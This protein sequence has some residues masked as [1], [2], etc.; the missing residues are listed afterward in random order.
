[1]KFSF[2]KLEGF[3]K[4]E[5]KSEIVEEGTTRETDPSGSIRYSKTVMIEDLNYAIDLHQDKRQKD[6]WHLSFSTDYGTA[7]TNKGLKTYRLV[8]ENIDA[9]LRAAIDRD[10]VK[11]VEFAASAESLPVEVFSSFKEFLSAKIRENAHV[12]DNFSYVSNMGF[13]KKALYVKNGTVEIFESGKRGR[14]LK[15]ALSGEDPEWSNDTVMPIDQ[16]INDPD[17]LGDLLSDK[18][19]LDSFLRHV[20]GGFSFEIKPGKDSADQRMNLYE[21]T[22]KQSF[23]QY[24]FSRKGGVISI[25]VK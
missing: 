3:V 4:P 7:I 14:N 23:P 19:M 6:V 21:R 10:N 25:L 9:L 5:S 8:I 24:D 22:L 15:S 18:E 2:E 16:F 17:Q 1:M 11:K 13:Y 12:F 20:R